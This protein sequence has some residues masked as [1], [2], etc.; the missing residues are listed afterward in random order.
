MYSVAIT[1]KTHDNSK[2]KLSP[3]I[4]LKTAKIKQ[5]TEINWNRNTTNIRSVY[6]YSD[7]LN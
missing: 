2:I 4:L 6:V 3:Y 1:L 5:R 7:T